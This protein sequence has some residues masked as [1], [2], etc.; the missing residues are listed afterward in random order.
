[1]DLHCIII[2]E[3]IVFTSI[4]R[5]FILNHYKHPHIIICSSYSSLKTLKHNENIDVILLDNS[6]TGAANYE[7]ISF[8]RHKKNITKPVL[9]FSNMEIDINKARQKGANIFI[10]KPF[11]PNEVIKEIDQL[12]N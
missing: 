9:Y 5:R 8:L 6:I 1:M 12:L 4:I 2:S 3:D 11:I 10:K 7:I